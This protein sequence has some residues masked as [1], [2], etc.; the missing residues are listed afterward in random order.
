MNLKEITPT[1]SDRAEQLWDINF[2]FYILN[3]I[4]FML[5]DKKQAKHIIY[6]MQR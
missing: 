4:V 2:P 3:I 5:L 6:A 1:K